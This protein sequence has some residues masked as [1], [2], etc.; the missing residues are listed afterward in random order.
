[1]NGAAPFGPRTSEEPM[2]FTRDESWAAALRSWGV[3]LLLICTAMSAA[4]VSTPGMAPGF[5]SSLWVLLLTSFWT[6]VLGGAVSAVMMLCALPVARRIGHGLRT[7]PRIGVHIATYAG[8]GAVTGAL[9]GVLVAWVP[10]LGAY[11]SASS[12]IGFALLGAAFTAPSTA[13]GWWLTAR[14]ALRADARFMNADT[15]KDG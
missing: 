12:V 13:L 8:L 7:Q 11:A 5:F 3:F 2:A 14:K 6:S 4:V 9:A 15:E 1:M 10:S